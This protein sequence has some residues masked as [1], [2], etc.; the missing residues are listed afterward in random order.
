MWDLVLK[1]KFRGKSAKEIENIV[2]KETY[3]YSRMVASGVTQTSRSSGEK[4]PM[5]EVEASL[6]HLERVFDNVR[7]IT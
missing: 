6:Y 4:E 7:H 5:I 1:S 2:R 3:C